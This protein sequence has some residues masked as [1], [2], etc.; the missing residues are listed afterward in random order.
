MLAVTLVAALALAACSLPFELPFDISAPDIDPKSVAEA[1]QEARENTVPEVVPPTIHENGYLVVGIRTGYT[2]AP[3]L[4]EG[5]GVAVA[6]IDIDLASA[7]ADELGLQV[8]FLAVA[9]VEAALRADCDVVMNVIPE[10]VAG[11][12]CVGSYEQ[13]AL[14]FF[15]KGTPGV[16]DAS[17]IQGSS[18]AV[19]GAS[20]TER[21]LASTGLSVDVHQCANI[22]E[23]FDALV[24]GEVDYVLCDS[25]QGSYL[26]KAYDGISF[27]GALEAPVNIGVGV[28]T[29]N[30]DLVTAVDSALSTIGRNG[31]LNLVL[32]RW[33]IPIPS[34]DESQMATNITVSAV[35]VA[36]PGT[37]GS[38]GDSEEQD[39]TEAL[40]AEIE[41]QQAAEGDA[42]TEEGT[43]AG[44]EEEGEGGYD[45]GEETGY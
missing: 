3:L 8:R 43:E 40:L 10:E 2:T 28:L 26:A 31:V 33:V 11:V 6:G 4:V 27:A 41:A 5:A 9:D 20:L 12:T 14:S 29:T 34:I 38:E 22:N 45:Y 44:T 23:C 21:T 19:Q 24:A 32:N 17:D 37:E 30:P 1:E 42:Q 39:A 36:E 35:E 13:S 18:V 15:R 7:L 16:V 25:L